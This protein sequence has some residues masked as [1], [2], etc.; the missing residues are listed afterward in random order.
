MSDEPDFPKANHALRVLRK[1]RLSRNAAAAQMIGDLVY[2][3]AGTGER[4]PAIEQSARLH[5]MRFPSWQKPSTKKRLPRRRYG[6]P[7][8]ERQKRG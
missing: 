2:E 5:G 6:R 1:A 8:L 3:V 4:S 7:R